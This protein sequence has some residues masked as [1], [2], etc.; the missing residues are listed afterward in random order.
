MTR[1]P[2]VTAR[3][4]IRSLALAASL[5]ASAAHAECD[6]YR[7][8]EADKIAFGR[9]WAQC[10]MNA[11]DYDARLGHPANEAKSIPRAEKHMWRLGLCLQASGWQTS[12][13]A[14]WSPNEH[15]LEQWKREGK[16][17]AEEIAGLEAAIAHEHRQAT[18]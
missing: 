1:R 9:A 14:A 11:E 8:I 3:A 5:L 7:D 16:C 4:A 17:T 2:R 18:P 12:P 13:E 6:A 15:V 10:E